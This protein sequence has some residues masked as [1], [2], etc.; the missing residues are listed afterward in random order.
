MNNNTSP[1]ENDDIKKCIISLPFTKE[2]GALDLSGNYVI[3]KDDVPIYCGESSRL[4][5]RINDHKSKFK[6][7]GLL[8]GGSKDKEKGEVYRVELFNIGA[9][10]E[11][12][13]LWEQNYHSL[14]GETLLSNAGDYKDFEFKQKYDYTV[15]HRNHGVVV[16]ERPLSAFCEKYGLKLRGFSKVLYEGKPSYKG[17]SLVSK[18]KI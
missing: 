1:F 18:V 5:S 15:E 12:R 3:L 11:E 9:N 8:D 6:N 16:V 4:L 13:L 7:Q 10:K 14:H 17:W 2:W